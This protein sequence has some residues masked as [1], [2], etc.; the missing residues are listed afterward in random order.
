LLHGVQL[1]CNNRVGTF[2]LS[3]K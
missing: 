2:L 3:V 1:A